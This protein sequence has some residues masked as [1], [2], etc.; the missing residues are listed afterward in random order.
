M[1]SFSFLWAVSLV[2]LCQ[3]QGSSSVTPVFVKKGDDVLLNVTTADD[4]EEDAVVL[5]K[6]NKQ[7][8][9]VRFIP[10]R[11][12][13]V[14]PVYTGR[15]EFSVKNYSMKLKNLEEADSGVYTA[16]ATGIQTQLILA[17][18]NVIVQDP[19]S[20]VELTVDSVSRSSDSCNLTVTCSTQ[21]S[22]INSTFRCDNQNCSQEGGQRSQV[23]ASG[24]SLH[25]YLGGNGSI[26][27]N[28][29]NNV[30]WIEDMKTIEHF[31]RDVQD[32]DSNDNVTVTVVVCFVI[33][34]LVI[35]VFAAVFF[36]RRRGKYKTQ[37]NIDNTVYEVPQVETTGQPRYQS[38]AGDASG[39]SPTSTY[40]LVGPHAGNMG[41]TETKGKTLPETLY[42]QVE[43]TSKS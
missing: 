29:S 27:C 3:M 22:H 40:S 43:K 32:N 33:L 1:R 30:S 37:Q 8:I 41:S 42:A 10:D 18:H 21:D 24:A 12:P 17:E 16:Q 11:E 7:T 28:H 14:S 34:F 15:L 19:V 39:V 9:L 25:V 31:C 35:V 23:T 4:L 13:T 38:P 6:F 36:H 20:P 2:Y 5:W 26:I